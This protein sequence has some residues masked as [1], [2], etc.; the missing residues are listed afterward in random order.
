MKTPHIKL[1]SLHLWFHVAASLAVAALA[2]NAAAAPAS[3]G[4][5]KPAP[6]AFDIFAKENLAAWCIVPFDA[7]KRGPKERAAMLERLGLTMLAYDYRAE[8]IPTFDAEIAA[9]KRHHIKLLAWWFPGGLNSEARAILDCIKRNDVHPQLWVMLE[10]GPHLRWEQALERTPEAQ[11]AH[12][13]RLVAA[14]KPI[15]AEAAKLGCQVA[16]Y[17]H[18]GWF[19]VPENQIQILERLR[20]DGVDNVGMVYTQH[21]GHGDS[22]RFEQLFPK[23]KP[24]LLAV[25]LNGMIKD[26]DLRGHNF[27]TIPLGQGDQDLRLLRIIKQ[28]GWRG[29]VSIINESDADAELRLLDN[30]EGLDWLNRQLKGQPVGPP[31]TP[32]S[33][34]KTK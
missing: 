1:H 11:A 31:P 34:K 16:L 14:A 24:Y 23:M 25:S 30:L 12:V 27:G 8:H 7:K 3:A 22:D 19:G 2:A 13:A 33:W 15:A 5:E 6:P 10:G 26:G 9:L 21:H 18:G 20:R 32:R 29:P 17:N 4:P 28:S